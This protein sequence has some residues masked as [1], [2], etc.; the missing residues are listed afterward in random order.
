MTVYVV[1]G[2]LRLTGT[3][4]GVSRFTFLRIEKGTNM[5]TRNR[6]LVDDAVRF[7][8]TE[9]EI[10]MWDWPDGYP[11]GFFYQTHEDAIW[12][13]LSEGADALGLHDPIDLVNYL[14]AENVKGFPNAETQ[15]F[16]S[17]FDV[18]KE[19]VMLA[20]ENALTNLDTDDCGEIEVTESP[21]A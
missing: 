16:R 6:F 2:Q 18:Q 1:R 20:C 9:D 4:T 13:V 7:G 15:I 11:F 19:M 8:V 3:A 21:L 14:R 5:N 12:E 17:L 10:S